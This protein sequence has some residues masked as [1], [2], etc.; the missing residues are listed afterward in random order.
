MDAFPKIR[1]PQPPPTSNTLSAHQRAQLVRRTKKLAKILG[2]VPRLEDEPVHLHLDFASSPRSSTDSARSESSASTYSLSSYESSHSSASK[3]T[4]TRTSRASMPLTRYFRDAHTRTQK[5]NSHPSLSL[6]TLPSPTE[7]ESDPSYHFTIPTP[8]AL[9]K[10]KIDRLR[11]VLGEDVPTAL[12]FPAPVSDASDDDSEVVIELAP[13]PRPQKRTT[14]KIMHARDSLEVT[15]PPTPQKQ[16][17]RLRVIQGPLPSRPAP[18]PPLPASTP[19]PPSTS[20]PSRGPLPSP[21]RAK[22][23]PPKRAVRPL[24]RVPSTRTPGL[25]A[26]SE[27]AESGCTLVR[28]GSARRVPVRAEYVCGCG[29]HA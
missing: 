16:K 26:I 1:F 3:S 28:A 25:C 17:P 7:P 22:A 24:P 23:E 4:T 13:T 15:P 21:F 20:L 10:Q 14:R 5:H 19:T 29:G 2:T 12:V 6:S 11:R 8:T 9:R 27:T 18:P